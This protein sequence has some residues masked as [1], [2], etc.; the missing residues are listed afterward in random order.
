[1]TAAG[2]ETVELEAMGLNGESVTSSDFFLEA[3]DV[4]VFELHNL[5]AVRADEVVVVAFMGDVVVL[6]LC[7]EVPRLRQAGFAKEI[8]CAID[9][10]QP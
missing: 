4:A 8:Q 3:F 2:T 1:M 10:R 5:S 6:S 7:A 9:R